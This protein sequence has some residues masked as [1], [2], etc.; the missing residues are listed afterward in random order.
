M[1]DRRPSIIGLP[2]AQGLY[3]PEYEHDACGVGFICHI[4][5]K[6]SN[7]IV[8]NALTM[9]ERM[10]HRGACGCEPDS[11]DGAGIM[12]RLPDKFLRRE[13]AKKGIT[14][15]K[16]GEYAVG[17][18]FLPK[19]MVSR[20]ACI[21]MIEDVV[22]G[23]EMKILGWRDVHTNSKYVGPTPRKTAPKIR[24]CF[25]AP[26]EKFFNKADFDRRLYLVRGRAENEIPGNVQRPQRPSRPVGRSNQPIPGPTPG[27]APAGG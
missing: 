20:N 9:L 14:L 21:Q 1:S 26:D 2:P 15:P 12:V 6:A 25:V 8:D 13:M 7:S 10:N 23:Y 27:P 22:E 24:Q 4:K 5:G 16:F 3:L 17:T 18:V 19:D 11:G